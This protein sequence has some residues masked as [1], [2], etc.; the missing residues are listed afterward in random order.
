MGKAGGS[1]I[2]LSYLK[3]HRKAAQSAR[4]PRRTLFAKEQSDALLDSA[5]NAIRLNVQ[6]LLSEASEGKT[7][8]LIVGFGGPHPEHTTRCSRNIAVGC[9]FTYI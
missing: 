9:G 4:T 8:G 2:L 6:I 1:M 3:Q 7:I 5:A